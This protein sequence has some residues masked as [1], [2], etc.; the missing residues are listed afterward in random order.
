ML[1]GASPAN[2]PRL[3]SFVSFR[4]DLGDTTEGT[5]FP[6]FFLQDQDG[7]EYPAAEAVAISNDGKRYQYKLHKAFGD[8]NFICEADIL[9]WLRA[10]IRQA[11]LAQHQSSLPIQENPLKRRAHQR[12]KGI[13]L[14]AAADQT[15]L[16]GPANGCAR[17]ASPE[18]ARRSNPTRAA[19]ACST[20]GGNGHGPWACP[21][22]ADDDTDSTT[23]ASEPAAST[24]QMPESVDEYYGVYG[25][26]TDTIASQCAGNEEIKAAF[27]RH[28]QGAE[29]W[30]FVHER[31]DAAG[32]R[33]F[34]EWTQQ[35]QAAS[36]QMEHLT[37]AQGAS[38][39]K[40]LEHLDK[41][42]VGL[43]IWAAPYFQ[44]VH[45][46]QLEDTLK[47]HQFVY[48]PCSI[49]CMPDT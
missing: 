14:N 8:H 2:S 16:A 6:R 17:A 18:R 30:R 24:S 39:L 35:L 12:D 42:H 33:L 48:K 40:L 3:S 1:T 15:G 7:K 10:A 21:F 4:K 46:W 26:C 27:A 47:I 44:P 28:P 49:C 31:P 43:Q 13:A 37:K 25:N 41:Q 9:T 19:A 22:V 45:M 23:K 38:L 32:L 34:T 20:C 5:H 11:Q 36:D 29:L